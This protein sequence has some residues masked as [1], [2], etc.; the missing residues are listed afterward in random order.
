MR[1][2]KGLGFRIRILFFPVSAPSVLLPPRFF[3]LRDDY[4]GGRVMR[5]QAAGCRLERMGASRD[6]AKL[7]RIGALDQRTWSLEPEA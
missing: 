4:F 3:A 1:R 2:K 6:P 7:K 5:L